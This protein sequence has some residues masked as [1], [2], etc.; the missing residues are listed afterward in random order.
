MPVI[1]SDNATPLLKEAIVLDLGDIG[2]QAA[3]LRAAAEQRAMQTLTNAERKAKQ[4]I[5]GAAEKG[6]AQ[7]FAEGREQGLAEGREQG[8]AEAL[9]QSTEQLKQLQAGWTQALAG[10]EEHCVQMDRDS[11]Q[12]VLAFALRVAEK[13]VHRVVEVDEEV[14][15]KQ[16]AKALTYVL[17]ANEVT[18]T[19]HPDDRPTLEAAVPK[20][21]STFDQL[22]HIKLVDDEAVGRGGCVV[23]GGQGRVDATIDTQL[24]RVVDAILPGGGG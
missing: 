8:R 9:A 21:L 2:R 6:H 4:L 22:E 16:L 24:Q 10:W 17:H 1:K 14:V 23:R 12:A 5:D 13:L 15:V 19:V 3:K 18:V 7:G 20:L 11:R